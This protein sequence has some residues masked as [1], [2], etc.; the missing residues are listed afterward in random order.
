MIMIVKQYIVA[1]K[2]IEYTIRM[3]AL[4]LPH[5]LITKKPALSHA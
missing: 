4:R 5:A 2:N 1:S 3:T